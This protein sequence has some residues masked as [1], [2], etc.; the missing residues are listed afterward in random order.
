LKPIL[1]VFLKGIRALNQAGHGQ[2]TVDSVVASD[3][4]GT[5]VLPKGKRLSHGGAANLLL[6][7]KTLLTPEL[8]VTIEGTSGFGGRV[9]ATYVIPVGAMDTEVPHYVQPSSVGGAGILG[10]LRAR[11]SSGKGGDTLELML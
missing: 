7:S 5:A 10:S 2:V 3:P 4:S 1:P 6:S 11:R 8:T 9:H